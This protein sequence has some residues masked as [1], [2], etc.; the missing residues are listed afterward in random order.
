MRHD[1]A[2]RQMISRIPLMNPFITS[3][4]TLVK[5]LVTFAAC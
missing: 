3:A 4:Y 1:L 2:V 5:T